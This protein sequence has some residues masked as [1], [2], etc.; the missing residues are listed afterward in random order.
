MKDMKGFPKCKPTYKQCSEKNT[1]DTQAHTA[2]TQAHTANTQDQPRHN[3]VHFF[4]LDV[5]V[6]FSTLG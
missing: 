2:N 3:G 6:N 5:K 1:R 4:S